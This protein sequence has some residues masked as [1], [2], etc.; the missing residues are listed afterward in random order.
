METMILK[1]PA[2]LWARP[3]FDSGLF[4]HIL[5]TINAGKVCELDDSDHSRNRLVIFLGIR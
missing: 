2:A 5:D 1:A 3:M 4:K